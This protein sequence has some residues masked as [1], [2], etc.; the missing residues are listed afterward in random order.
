MA[1]A[2]SVAGGGTAPFLVHRAQQVLK[3]EDA[4]AELPY[5]VHMF[6]QWINNS[7]PVASPTLLDARTAQI[8]EL[9]RQEC[10][11]EGLLQK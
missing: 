6:L 5:E 7:L 3:G 2:C 10:E 9:I 11:L 8:I 4:G 1:H